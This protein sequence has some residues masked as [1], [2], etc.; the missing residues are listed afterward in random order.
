MACAK[1]EC[2]WRRHRDADQAW[3][4]ENP[5]YDDGRENYLRQWRKD[6][7][8][9]STAYRKSHP[10][11]EEQNRQRQR[12]RSRERRE[13]GKQDAIGRVHE[14]KLARIQRLID[15]GKQDAIRTPPLRVSEEIRRYLRWS[16]RVGKQD[17]IALQKRIVDNRGH[18]PT[19]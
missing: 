19:A 8:G 15:L 5:D 6:H 18:E 14:E 11:Y 1:P 7:P 12:E 2:Q 4:Q 16:Y 9:F 3:H 13:F 10:K 17:V